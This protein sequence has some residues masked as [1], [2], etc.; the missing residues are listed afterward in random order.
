M[1]TLKLF[2]PVL[3][4]LT[5]VSCNKKNNTTSPSSTTSNPQALVPDS[6]NVLFSTSLLYTVTATSTSTLNYIE[7]YALAS[8]SYFSNFTH[9][10]SGPLINMDTVRLNGKILVNTSFPNPNFYI[11]SSSNYM[12]GPYIWKTTGGAFPALTFTNTDT[13]CNYTNY[14]SWPDTIS[15]S[16]GLSLSLT[17]TGNADDVWIYLSN[18][19]STVMSASVN[20]LIGSSPSYSFSPA[21]LSAISTAS[22][23]VIS[24]EFYTNNIQT[25]S[26]KRINFRNRTIYA[27]NVGVKN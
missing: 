17:G 6:F 8:N 23:A 18:T 16:N 25:I 1:K 20:V 26:G 13:Y 27:K 24:I 4:L 10:L 9:N 11:D 3:F 12:F 19:Q 14:T 5:I 15:K 21:S 22:D 2:L 7:N